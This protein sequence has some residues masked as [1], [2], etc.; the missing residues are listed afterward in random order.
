MSVESSKET[1]ASA[2][3]QRRHH[4]AP[5]ARLTDGAHCDVVVVGAGGGG[6]TA[7][8]SAAC[9]GM[10]VIVLE[11]AP[12]FG[13]ITAI[14]GGGVWIPCNHIAKRMGIHD[15]PEDA[16][17]YFRQCAGEYYDE[18]RAR[19]FLGA[20]PEMIEFLEKN[21]EVVF[22]VAVGRPDYHPLIPGANLGGGR[23]IHPK[24][25]NARKLGSEVARLKPPSPEM[26]FLGLMIKPGPDLRH[27]LNVFRSVESTSF[28]ARR[29]LCHF[30][31]LLLHG[32]AMNLSNG[33]ALI[34]RL[35]KSAF[36]RGVRIHT[37]VA[38]SE[39]VMEGQR[40]VGVRFTDASS[41]GTV[42]ARRG[43]VLASGGFPHDIEKRRQLFAHAPTGY[44]HWSPA[45]ETHTGDGIRMAEAVN[46]HFDTRLSNPA[47]W[48]PVSLVP[49]ENGKFVAFAHLIDRQK[50][51]FIAVT[52]TGRRFVNE[53]NSYHDFGL[54]LAA[55][56]TGEAETC[57]FL[58]A[59][60]ATVR[61]YGIGA[62]KP[63][64]VPYKSHLRTGYLIQADTLDALAK[65]AGIDLAE[66]QRTVDDFNRSAASGKDPLFGRGENPYNR[67]NGDPSHRP[68]PCIAPLG[69][70]P[71]C[72][73]K[74]VM[75]ELGTFAGI[76]SDA[77][78][79]ALDISGEV[80]PGLYAA[81]N[82][83]LNVMGGD[84][85]SGGSTLGPGMVAGYMAA[86]D[87]VDRPA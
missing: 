67:Y 49:R 65:K 14:S 17:T 32:R 43:V 12:V 6:L 33:N 18:E 11:K 47:G 60:L 76:R 26:T 87:M 45:P 85:M 23:T 53:A 2:G 78:G 54:A 69:R 59:S 58:V 80:I 20:G 82:D 19:A 48:A 64:P 3:M 61:R 77:H 51:G 39:L 81:G 27:F 41:T 57:A 86:R 52:R 71:F 7:A 1:V 70:G 16:L 72:A 34:G 74:L 13:G 28:V 15:T 44:E 62:V 84:Y 79:R 73:V 56:C 9:M 25:Y 37:S 66:L 68:N 22:D 83:M 50:P 40:V 30:R 4:D 31:D 55:A 46:A 35:A 75:G 21:T 63:A 8:L 29:V 5:D 38:A 36:D 42:H 10:D 24:S